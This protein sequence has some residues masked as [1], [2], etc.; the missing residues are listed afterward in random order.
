MSL[1]RKVALDFLVLQ[2]LLALKGRQVSVETPVH[3][4]NLGRT[5]SLGSEDHRVSRA[6]EASLAPQ[7]SKELRE[8]R[9][10]VAFQDFQERQ[11]GSTFF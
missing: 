6:I 4:V 5:V 7:A 9:A 1:E 3:W 11:S 10:I 8:R 2:G